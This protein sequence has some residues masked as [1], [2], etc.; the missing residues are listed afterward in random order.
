MV[1]FQYARASLAQ[2]LQL[3]FQ[4]GVEHTDQRTD[5]ENTADGHGQHHK[6]EARS[7][8][9]RPSCPDPECASGWPKLLLPSPFVQSSGGANPKGK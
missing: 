2:A 5:D 6:A 9:R 4:A 1:V 7:R 3:L 8:Y